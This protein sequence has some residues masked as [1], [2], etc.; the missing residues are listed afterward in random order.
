MLHT[1]PN[2]RTGIFFYLLGMSK[3][4]DFTKQSKSTYKFFTVIFF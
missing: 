3:L 1:H 2:K 4:L